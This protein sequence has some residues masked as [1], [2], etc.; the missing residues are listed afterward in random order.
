MPTE[1]PWK[2]TAV[3]GVSLYHLMLDPMLNKST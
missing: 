3:I 1:E 2:A